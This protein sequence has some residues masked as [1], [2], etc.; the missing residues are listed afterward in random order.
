[1]IN[2]TASSSIR[3]NA[4]VARVWEALTLPAQVKQYFF[5]TQLVTDWRVGS[6]IL[7]RGEWEGKPYEDKGVVVTFQPQQSLSYS[8]ASAAS[9]NADKPELHQLIR[10]DLQPG[11]NEVKI[12]VTQSNAPTQADADHSAE[13]WNTVLGN[14]KELVEQPAT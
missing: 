5:G 3:V 7:F 6:P 8:Y 13:N 11:S 2:F 4:T 9:G 10:Y 1:M 14:L 12:T